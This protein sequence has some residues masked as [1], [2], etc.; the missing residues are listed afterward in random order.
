[1]PS[2]DRDPPEPEQ[3]V[4]SRIGVTALIERRGELLAATGE[5]VVA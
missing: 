3:N 2:F 5:I 1:V 4:P